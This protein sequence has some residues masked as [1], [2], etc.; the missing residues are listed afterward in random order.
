MKESLVKWQVSQ[1]GGGE[2]RWSRDGRELFYFDREN[3]LTAVEVKSA[4][5]R[6]ETEG[7]RSCSSLMGP[8]S[9]ADGKKFLVTAELADQ[10]TSLI[11]LVTNWPATLK[12]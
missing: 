11:T 5:G 8:A 3:R 10:A 6:F 4:S 9:A 1:E 12:R 7:R 2:P